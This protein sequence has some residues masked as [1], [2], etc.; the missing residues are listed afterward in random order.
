MNNEEIESNEGSIIIIYMTII[1]IM[2]IV[3][4]K[5]NTLKIL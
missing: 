1:I 2:M 5:R 3:T 4:F